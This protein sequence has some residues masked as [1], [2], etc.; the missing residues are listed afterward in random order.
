MVNEKQKMNISLP[1]FRYEALR[2]I[3]SL[4]KTLTF[5]HNGWIVGGAAKYMCGLIDAPRD[6]DIIIPPAEWALAS[7]SFP[8]GS[9]INTMGGVKI[10]ENNIEIDVWASDLGD[11][12]LTSYGGFDLIAVS[13][14]TQ[15]VCYCSKR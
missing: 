6:W 7:K 9:L 2:E 12:F 14:K 11:H 13:P 15:Q 5:I 8:H 10:V 4:V 1:T 3:P